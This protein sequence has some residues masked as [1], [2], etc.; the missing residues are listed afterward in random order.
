M[1]FGRESGVK[2]AWPLS[3]SN[4]ARNRGA[5]SGAGWAS[6]GGGAQELKVLYQDESE[7]GRHSW[8]SLSPSKTLAME[9]YIY[10]CGCL[11]SESLRISAMAGGCVCAL[12][13]A[14]CPHQH[15]ASH[16]APARFQQHPAKHRGIAVGNNQAFAKSKPRPRSLP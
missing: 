6:G 16:N 3:S 4:P 7:G 9:G 13:D 15:R 1:G 5:R 12:C 10:R 14:I 8:K 11:P 2:L